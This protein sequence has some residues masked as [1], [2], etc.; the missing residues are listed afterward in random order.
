[1]GSRTAVCS[2][3]GDAR[4]QARGELDGTILGAEE[5]PDDL[6]LR[7]DV[8]ERVR[9][10]REDLGRLGEA[11]PGERFLDV[12]RGH[13]ADAAQILGED[14]VGL[15]TADQVGVESVQ[16]LLGVH[17][18]PHGRVDLAR[19]ERPALG[20]RAAGDD[21]LR[22]RVGREVAF[23]GHADQFV[24][25]PERVDDL[26]GRRQQGHDLHRGKSP[27]PSGVESISTRSVSARPTAAPSST[28]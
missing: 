15:L 22:D 26:G 11:E 21:R 20:E 13:G 10:E 25:Q 16:R 28:R 14:H 3:G 17:A 19:R 8:V 7:D 18:V 9:V 23:V 24:A 5:L 12:A 27:S 4:T 2:D 1:M 6:D